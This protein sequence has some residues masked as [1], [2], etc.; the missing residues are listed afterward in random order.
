[1][2]AVLGGVRWRPTTQTNPARPTTQLTPPIPRRRTQVWPFVTN[3]LEEHDAPT[4]IGVADV[5]S[6]EVGIAPAE[7]DI[8]PSEAEDGGPLGGL[9]PSADAAAGAGAATALDGGDEGAAA[10]TRRPPSLGENA[11]GA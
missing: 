10:S 8:A 9:P 5:V 1:M 2:R 4:Y 6:S 7:V 3:F 11:S